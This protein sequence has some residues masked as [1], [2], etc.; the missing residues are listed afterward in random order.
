L[1]EARK[2]ISLRAL[3]R[4]LGSSG[5]LLFFYQKLNRVRVYAHPGEA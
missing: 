4:L 1:L 2:M 3:R 5:N